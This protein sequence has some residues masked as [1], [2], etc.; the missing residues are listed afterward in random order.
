MAETSDY[1]GALD[2]FIDFEP[3]RD[4][5]SK[6]H[7]NKV[8][9]A[10]EA[11]QAELGT[12]PAGS[13][14]DVKTRLY[15]SLDNDGAVRHGT[16]FPGSPIEGQPFW[17]SDEKVLYIYDATN[18]VW[19]SAQSYSNVVF[20]VDAS[21]DDI[22]AEYVGTSL[23]P[24]AATGNYRFFV[25]GS[26]S[27]TTI[28]RTKFTK[29]ATVSTITVY[30]QLWMQNTDN[31]DEGVDLKVDIGGQNGS[32]SRIF[33]DS[34]PTTPVWKSF[35]INVSSL[36]TGTVYDVVIQLKRVGAQNLVYM[37]NLIAFGS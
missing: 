30:A 16:S 25:Q 6:A 3:K 7:I 24:S 20:Q 13:V 18:L 35:T 28:K 4:V 29:L 15:V 19:K 21:V 37:G 23:V 5:V 14:T 33:S 36:T 11:M 2:S 27:Y 8:Q 17:R 22:N 9:N 12:D 26:T 34:T 32:V 10:I 1:P 31:G